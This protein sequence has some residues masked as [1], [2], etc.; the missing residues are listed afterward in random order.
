MV[1]TRSVT[2]FNSLCQKNTYSRCTIGK[3]ETVKLCIC[4][5]SSNT[6]SYLCYSSSVKYRLKIHNAVAR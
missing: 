2:L 1:F 6:F 4:L 3:M 5:L